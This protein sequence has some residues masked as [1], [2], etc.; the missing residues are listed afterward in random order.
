MNESVGG[1]I[2]S[3]LDKKKIATVDTDT[4]AAYVFFRQL[5]LFGH[6]LMLNMWLLINI[7]LD[8]YFIVN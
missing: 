8:I 1:I 5:L 3:D 6:T 2:L 7:L 4:T